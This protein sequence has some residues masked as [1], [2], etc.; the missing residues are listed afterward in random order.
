MVGFQAPIKG[1][2]MP[3]SLR[4][5]AG[6]SLALAVLAVAPAAVLASA[7]DPAAARIEA[8][9]RSLVSVMKEGPALG[10]RGRYRKLEP[11]VKDAFDLPLMT[12]YAVG[13]TAWAAMS[14][15]DHQALIHAFTKLTAA[16][17]AHTFDRFAGERFD[18]VP[19]VQSR[20]PDK[21]VES[22]LTP[23]S[24]ASVDL[25]YRMRQSGGTWTIAAPISPLPWP[26]AA[27]RASSP[28]STPPARSCCSSGQPSFRSS[29]PRSR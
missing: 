3:I 18:V 8:F 25:T 6:A 26:R 21:V 22:H 20:G 17:Y 4:S 7:S 5:L 15:A 27:P 13:P 19:A 14:E 11:V 28:T 9:D 24:G 12:R 16:S 23:G 1:E 10:P 29:R 2:A